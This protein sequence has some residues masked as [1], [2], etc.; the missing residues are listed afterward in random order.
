MHIPWVAIQLEALYVHGKDFGGGRA[1]IPPGGLANRQI[2]KRRTALAGLVED[3]GTHSLCSGFVTEA[4]GAECPLHGKQATAIARRID[5]DHVLA[6]LGDGTYANVHLAWDR[7][8]SGRNPDKYPTSF[9]Y[10]SPEAFVSA[11]QK[12]FDEW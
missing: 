3:Y 6:R 1:A 10:G 9:V 11:M 5:C 4:G 12:D 7:P 2:A 8:R